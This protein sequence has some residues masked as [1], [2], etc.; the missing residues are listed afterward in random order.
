MVRFIHR[1]STVAC[2]L[3]LIV[4]ACLSTQLVVQ[5]APV[6]L[7]MLEAE[8]YPDA[9]C[10][11]GTQAGYYYEEGSTNKKWVIYLNG[12]GECDNKEACEAQMSNALGSSKYFKASQDSTGWY[13]A[14]PYCTNNPD[15]CTWNH[16]LNPYCS[17]DLHAG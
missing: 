5:S 10:L 3:A 6:P 9:K 8:D 15:F 2:H 17:Q 7:T 13:I 14:S 11:D 12:G 16:V 4:L 1:A